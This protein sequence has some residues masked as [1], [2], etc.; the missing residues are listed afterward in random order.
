MITEA[1]AERARRVI[2]ALLNEIKGHNVKIDPKAEA[3]AK[4]IV[5]WT[6]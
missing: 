1:E 4:S 2:M 3:E 5:G 6:E